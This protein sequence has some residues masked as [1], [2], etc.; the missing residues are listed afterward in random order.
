MSG[1]NLFGTPAKMPSDA[2]PASAL[3]PLDQ[4]LFGDPAQH[5]MAIE[6]L[7]MFPEIDSEARYFYGQATRLHKLYLEMEQ[8]DPVL[9]GII[10]QRRAAVLTKTRRV[11]PASMCARDLFIA[12]FVESVLSNIGGEDGGFDGDL[13]NMLGA[14]PMGHSICEVIWQHVSELNI[15]RART[16]AAQDMEE[17][18]DALLQG[19]NWIL[20]VQIKHL[21]PGNF[22]FDRTGQMYRVEM[23]ERKLV[24]A[25]KYLVMRFGATYENPYGTGLLQRLEWIYRFKK[26]AQRDWN[27]ALSRFGSPTAT[28]E[29]PPEIDDSQR[30]AANAVLSRIATNM[31]ALIPEGMKLNFLETATATGQSPFLQMM[32]YLDDCAA[33]C[34]L[35]TSLTTNAG[36]SGGSYAQATVLSG[37][38]ADKVE[39]DARLLMWAVNRNLVRWIVDLNFGVDVPAPQWIIDTRGIDKQMADIALDKEYVAI[40]GRLPDSYLQERYLRPCVEPG[41]SF[42]SLEQK[43]TD[44]DEAAGILTINEMRGRR[45]LPPVAWG[46]ERTGG[47]GA[48]VVPAPAVPMPEPDSGET[49]APQTTPEEPETDDVEPPDMPED[50]M[51]MSEDNWRDV[52]LGLVEAD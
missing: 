46:E 14:L 1:Q 52:I 8:K 43:I 40:G 42:V 15:N 39:G 19:R 30:A 48:G 38:A 21:F 32:T 9:Y 13:S 3:V 2:T 31:G 45:G 41:D 27:L 5:R 24:E 4:Y 29:I 44:A 34:V 28:L 49:A 25:R 33:K 36:Q 20:P 6:P 7:T 22:V 50:K 18:P 16:S 26:T 10:E 17:I 23:A 51:A 11:V 47:V 12:D 37:V 35:G